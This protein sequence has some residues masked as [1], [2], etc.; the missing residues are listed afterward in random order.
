MLAHGMVLKLGSY[1]LTSVSA[2][3]PILV[4]LV[5]R[6]GF[7]SE[8]LWVGWCPCCSIR[9][10]AW[11]QEVASSGPT[12]PMLWVTAKDTPI[13]SWPPPLSQVSVSFWRCAHPTSPLLSVADFHFF[14]RAIWPSLLSLPSFVHSFCLL[15]QGS[16]SPEERDLLETSYLGPSVLRP[17]T[18][19]VMSG[20]GSLYLFPSTS[21]EASL[22]MAVSGTDLQVSQDAI[23]GHFI[24]AFHLSVCL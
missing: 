17:L 4:F 7:A 10:L 3:S 16:L 14:L 6:I 24:T 18:L 21:G 9:L 8:V 20:C 22:M 15:P 5:D 19:C 23:G 11:L 2:S 1:R 12:F 13:D